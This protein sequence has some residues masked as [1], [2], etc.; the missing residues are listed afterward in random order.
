MPRVIDAEYKVN[1]SKSNPVADMAAKFSGVSNTEDAKFKE[2][3]S[4]KQKTKTFTKGL[5]KFA[6]KATKVGATIGRGVKRQGRF[7]AKSELGSAARHPFEAQK[8][9]QNYRL[10]QLEYKEAKAGHE[11]RGLERKVQRQQLR[12][13]LPKQ[14]REY[15]P[16]SD[17]QF[18]RKSNYGPL[19]DRSLPK[20][21]FRV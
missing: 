16:L 7:I 6:R 14:N 11:L 4:F 2:K 13:I 8:R 12:D 21:K 20:K 15:K 17:K 10:R 18:S 1:Y 19:S 9:Y 3:R 5:G